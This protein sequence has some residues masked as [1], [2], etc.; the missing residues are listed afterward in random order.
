[1]VYK[2]TGDKIFLRRTRNPLTLYMV[3]GKL[4]PTQMLMCPKKTWTGAYTKERL[5]S[6]CT[7]EM[8]RVSPLKC[9]LSKSQTHR[10]ATAR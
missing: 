1:M 3:Y 10:T 8:K 9:H 4:V 2:N 5:S 6:Q 7:V